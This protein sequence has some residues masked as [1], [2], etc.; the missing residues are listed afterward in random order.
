MSR[1]GEVGERH[2]GAGKEHDGGARPTG[3][4]SRHA[5]G[6]VREDSVEAAF[7]AR[8]HQ[9]RARARPWVRPVLLMDREHLA[10]GM[11]GILGGPGIRRAMPF[12]N[13]PR[14]AGLIAPFANSGAPV[15]GHA[16]AACVAF[17]RAIDGSPRPP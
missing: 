3:C 15:P 2:A 4:G 5:P 13:R 7:S 16:P 10:T 1:E 9:A 17:C 11:A 14:M 12:P 8:A 6:A